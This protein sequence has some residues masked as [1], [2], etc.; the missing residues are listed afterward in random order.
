MDKKKIKI[1]YL[2][3]IKLLNKYNKYYYDQSNPIVTDQKY[4]ELKKE[5]LIFEKKN[6]NLL[7]LDSPSLNVGFKPSKNFIKVKHKMPMLSLGNAFNE[8][9]LINFEKKN[10][11][12]FKF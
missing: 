9:D 2:N 3:K 8:E 4:D 11:K 5:I 6:P 10:N 12:L 7:S 1:D